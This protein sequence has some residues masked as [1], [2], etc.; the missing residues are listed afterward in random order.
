MCRHAF[1]C[2]THA[3]RW[4]TRSLNQDTKRET[5]SGRACDNPSWEAGDRAR[6]DARPDGV[7]WLC[8]VESV[9]FLT[10]IAPSVK[11]PDD[12]EVGVAELL[13]EGVAPLTL[14]RLEGP[15]THLSRS[16]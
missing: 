16:P 15:S 2:G 3:S 4:A 1:C 11:P 14:P 6:S 8:Q 7:G 9:E 5:C 12:G 13:G 10:A